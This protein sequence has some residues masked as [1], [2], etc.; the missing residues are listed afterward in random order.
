MGA[1][2]GPLVPPLTSTLL[3]SV[4][5]SRSGIAASVLNS[6]RQ[7][8]CALRV[9]LPGSL[10]GQA[11]AFMAGTHWSQIISACLLLA[12]GATNWFGASTKD[13]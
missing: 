8:G 2:L 12:A 3:G 9:A 7:T 13:S 5:K 1:G 10:A 6:T 11:N 4:E